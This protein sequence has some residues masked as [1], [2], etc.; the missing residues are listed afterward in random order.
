MQPTSNAD[1]QTNNADE[2]CSSSCAVPLC[3]YV[4]TS[5][6][7]QERDVVLMCTRATQCG[8]PSN[9]AHSNAGRQQMSKHEV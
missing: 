1:E 2:Q 7:I 5:V 3:T 6:T 4:V 9:G 8:T